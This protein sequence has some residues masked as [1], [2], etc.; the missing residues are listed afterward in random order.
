LLSPEA[1]IVITTHHRPDGDA[2]GS[3]LGLYNYLLKKGHKVTVITPS[4]YPDFLSWMKG[5]SEVLNFEKK[6]KQSAKLLEEADIIFCLDFNWLSRVEKMEQIVRNAN[7]KKILIDH[8]LDPE[9]AY[10]FVFSYSDACS[11]CELIYQFIESVGDEELIDKEIGECLYCGIMTDTNSFRYASMKADTHRIIASLI[12]A[13]VINYK[14]HELVYDNNSESRLRLTGYALAQKLV[15]LHEFATA[16]ISL[17]ERELNDFNFKAGDTEGLV[18]YALS[19][20]GIRMAA[21]FYERDNMVKISFR[22]KGDF[23]VQE[24]SLAYFQGGGHRNASGGKS[25]L[26]L[27][28]TIRKFIGILPEYKER[29]FE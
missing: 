9:D 17:T 11:T 21:F 27:E 15:V 3:S 29:L 1:R 25:V 23:S 5:N 7:G 2:I 13:G 22:S 4:D 6:E 12:E 14:V 19:V 18:N 8:H 24:L 26:S 20:Q 10:E 28:E 16:Y